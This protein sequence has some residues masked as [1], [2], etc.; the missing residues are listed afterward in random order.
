[1]CSM[2]RDFHWYI[3]FEQQKMVQFKNKPYLITNKYWYIELL[4][5]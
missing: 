2:S 3:Y 1:M 4:E 5:Q